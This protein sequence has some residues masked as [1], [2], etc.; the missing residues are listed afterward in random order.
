MASNKFE[1]PPFIV[2]TVLKVS[3]ALFLDTLDYPRSIYEMLKNYLWR[4]RT[5]FEA[6]L[7][8][9]MLEPWEKILSST[10]S[11]CA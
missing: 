7:A 4:Q 1:N 2:P 9:S 10:Y 6:T 5:K 8:F 11:F 3:L